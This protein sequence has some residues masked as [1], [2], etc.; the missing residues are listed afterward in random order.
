MESKTVKIHPRKLARSMAKAM[1]GSNK[2]GR[3]DWRGLA[4]EAAKSRN[5]KGVKRT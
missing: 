1:I 5:K 3:F 2:I 4:I